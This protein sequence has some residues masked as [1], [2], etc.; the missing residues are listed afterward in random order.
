MKK[1]ILDLMRKVNK[2]YEKEGLVF[3]PND[4][5]TEPSVEDKDFPPKSSFNLDSA[6]HHQSG[7]MAF[8]FECSLGT[9]NEI[10]ENPMVTH[11]DILDIQL[12]LYE[13]MFDTALQSKIK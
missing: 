5:I 4:W 1:N 6:L 10:D 8:T 12:N 13:E 11:A 7:T 9:I 3:T 2:R